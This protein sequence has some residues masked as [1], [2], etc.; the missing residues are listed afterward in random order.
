LIDDFGLTQERVA[1]RVGKSRAA[2]ANTLRLLN[3]PEAA[4]ESLEQNRITEGHARALLMIESP[5]ALLQA[6]QTVIR[7]NLSVRDTERLAR[8]VQHGSEMPLQESIAT[9]GSGET[10]LRVLE[11]PQRDPNE[12]S[13][14]ER[15]QHR[16]GTKVTL[17]RYAGGSGRIEIDFFSDQE[18]ERVVEILLGES[19]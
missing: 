19:L 13:V 17:R 6:L 15:L 18:L 1:K 4:Q 14:A 2:V 9:S 12:A 10:T 8:E 3:L 5:A 11:R 7:R 16:L